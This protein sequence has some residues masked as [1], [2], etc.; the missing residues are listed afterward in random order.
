MIPLAGS[1]KPKDENQT[2]C[3]AGSLA[4]KNSC[5][6]KERE[7]Q[8]IQFSKSCCHTAGATLTRITVKYNCGFP[9]NLFIRGEG[10]PGLSWDRGIAMKN[11]KADEWLWE[12]DKCFEKIQFK[13]ILNDRVYEQ[14]PNHAIECS[15]TGVFSPKF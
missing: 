14:G 10:M 13:I 3:T 1:K 5:S 12:T 11:V 2:S 6:S 9:N 8:E 15:K 4:A 7:V